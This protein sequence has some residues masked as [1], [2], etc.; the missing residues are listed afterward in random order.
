M[1]VPRLPHFDDTFPVK[2][3]LTIVSPHFREVVLELDTDFDVSSSQWGGWGII[4]WLLDA[5]LAKRSNFFLTIR[6]GKLSDREAV[7]LRA[8]ESFPR[9]AGKGRIRLESSHS[10]EKFWG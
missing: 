10:I 7:K 5:R 2:T 1:K 6:A 4:D 9:L 3:L 8:M